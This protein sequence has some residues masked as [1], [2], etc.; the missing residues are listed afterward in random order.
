MSYI[1]LLLPDFLLIVSGLLLCRYTA[2]DRPLWQAAERL[3]YYVLFPTLLFTAIARNPLKLQQATHLAL[4]GL[5]TVSC[6]IALAYALSHWPLINRWRYASGAQTAFRFNSYVGLAVADRLGGAPSVAWMAVLLAVCVPVCNLAA[7]LPLAKQ[8]GHS[9][10]REVVRNPMIVSTLAGLA[11]NLLSLQLPEVLGATLQR[12]A[13]A[14][15]PVGLMAVGAGLQLGSLVASP[16]M[17]VA[18]LGI[19]HA[20]LPLIALGLVGALGLPVAQQSVVVLF[21]ALP[22]ASGAYVLAARM[23]GDGPFVSG[24]VTLSTLLGMLSI[25]FWLGW[26]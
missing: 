15:L 12:V 13:A 26:V 11:F 7:V 3:V 23:G 16:R 18:F 8:G 2:L 25:P 22:T 19:R 14:A 6:G 1:L 20:V 9:V 24:L 4:A 21:A 10:G 5:G 17:A